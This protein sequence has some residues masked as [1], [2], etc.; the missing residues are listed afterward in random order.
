MEILFLVFY[1]IFFVCKMSATIAIRIFGAILIAAGLF[2]FFA[3][4]TT[5]E[6]YAAPGT[7]ADAYHIGL[8]Q[9]IG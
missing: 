9:V 4:I 5:L 1:K 7:K 3:P 6:L 8:T 2:Y